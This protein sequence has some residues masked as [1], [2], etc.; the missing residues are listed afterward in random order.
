[1]RISFLLSSVLFF[2]AC[3]M[4][5]PAIVD[6][7]LKTQTLMFSQKYK[8]TQDN[9]S[10]IVTMSYLN[11]VLDYASD[12]DIF[13]FTFTPDSFKIDKLEIFLNNKKAKVQELDPFFMKYL[14]QNKYTKY[15]EVT[16]PSVKT[17]NFVK[18]KICL[19]HL[20][21]F[22]LNFQKYPKSLYYRSE[23]IDIQYN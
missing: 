1:M 18:A 14:L 23:D 10:A 9:L 4:K 5:D 2:S 15:L 19:N 22:E 16:L 13:A 8:I 21:C 17:E 7:N 11:P 12:D 3:S 20:P 6:T